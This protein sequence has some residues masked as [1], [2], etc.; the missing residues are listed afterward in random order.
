M[1]EGAGVDCVLE[2][3]PHEARHST[4]FTDWP[5]LVAMQKPATAH[6]GQKGRA[7]VQA[8][9]AGMNAAA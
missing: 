8:A 5:L 9:V 1:G 6:E 7:S 2:Q 3:A 4:S